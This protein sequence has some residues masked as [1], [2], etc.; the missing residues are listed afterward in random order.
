MW[1]ESISRS[2]REA[3]LVALIS[4]RAS[5][6]KQ[7]IGRAH[8]DPGN[9]QVERAMPLTRTLQLLPACNRLAVVTAQC[10][11]WGMACAERVGAAGQHRYRPTI[12]SQPAAHPREHPRPSDHQSVAVAGAARGWRFW[13]SR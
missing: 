5:E 11:E 2:Y 4:K 9:H 10:M 12:F 8:V 1:G 13:C 6:F 7:E 3:G